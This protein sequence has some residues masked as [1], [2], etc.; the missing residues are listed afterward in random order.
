MGEDVDRGP[1][2]LLRQGQSESRIEDGGERGGRAVAPPVPAQYRRF[3]MPPRIPIGVSDF[4]ALREQGLVYVDKSHLIRALLDKGAQAFLLPRPRRF[5]KTL[6]LSMLRCFFEKRDEDLG[7]LF[8]GLSIWQAGEAYRAHFQRY[9]V[10]FITFKD[11]KVATWE[12]AW[13]AI[14]Q[15]ISALVDEHGYLLASDRLSERDVADLRAIVDGTAP[16][17][18][19]E[20]ALLLLSRCL[21]RHHGEKVVMLI[22]E[23]DEPIH[24]AWVGGS[25]PEAIAVMRSIL[26]A[27]LKD[28]PYLFKAVLTGILRI[29][30]ESIFSGLNNLD[31]YTL[32]AR[33]FS[34]CFGFTEPEV[35][36]LLDGAGLGEHRDT[37]RAWYDGYV[38]GDT[39][40]YNPWSI[41]TFVDRADGVPRGYWISTSSNDLVREALVRHGIAIEP[42]IEAL[43]GGG[44]IERALDE[45]VSLPDLTGR[46]DA[47]VSLLVLSGYLRAESAPVPAG[48]PP[49]YLLSIPNREVREVYAGTFRAFLRERLG[50]LESD[51]DRLKKAL[52][53]GDAEALEEQLQGFTE[54][55]LSY[56]DT[57]RRPEQVY[58]AFVLGLLAALEPEYLVRSNRESGHGRPDV[59]IRPRVPG[60][61]AVVLELKVARKGKKTPAAAIREGL[62]QI[63]ERGYEA[64][65]VAAGA[66]V[67][68]A[69][70]A[71]FDG[72]RVWVAAA[73]RAKKREPARRRG[74]TTRR[75]KRAAR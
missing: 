68:H 72:K 43:L 22:D 57:A 35:G 6:G 12:R 25:G 29:A 69:F 60:K 5:G 54:G 19:F 31:V 13:P 45:S 24:A 38:F 63:A 17:A 65:L 20:A 67:V 44:K 66:S 1:R 8:A 59:T 58:H 23:Y 46:P 3:G 33:D 40:I 70:A 15:K 41:L 71:A 21:H 52:I 55:L 56:H 2:E 50:G 74:A 9:P 26:S 18:T 62:A 7:G 75:P 61:P 32:L 27:G 14:Q 47:L 48:E 11:V 4:R 49:R 30:K 39:V 34:T 37:V 53:E 10:V 42:E 36:A 16:R 51:V 73:G 28:N 64:E